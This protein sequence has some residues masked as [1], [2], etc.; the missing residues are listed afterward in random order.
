MRVKYLSELNIIISLYRNAK[1]EALSLAKITKRDGKL[2]KILTS[3]VNIGLII[4]FL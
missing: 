3:C 2:V 4:T 1:L